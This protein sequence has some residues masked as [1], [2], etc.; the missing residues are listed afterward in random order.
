MFLLELLWRPLNLHSSSSNFYSTNTE[1]T[2][3][4]IFIVSI[5]LAPVKIKSNL[6]GLPIVY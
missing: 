1:L 6:E 2:L 5:P 3:K 4:G